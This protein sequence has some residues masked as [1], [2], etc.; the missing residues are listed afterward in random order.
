M[1]YRIF[2]NI[3][4][5]RLQPYVEKIAGNHQ[6]GFRVGKSAIYQIQ[7]LRETLEKKTL[8]YGGTTFGFV[9]AALKHVKLGVKMQNNQ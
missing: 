5:E 1:G 2:S 8:E 9:T 7:S 4:Y 3:L 6:C